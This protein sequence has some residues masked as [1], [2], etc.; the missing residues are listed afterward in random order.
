[1]LG[2]GEITI[3]AIAAL[4]IFF[5]TMVNAV[6]GLRAVAPETLELM[7]IGNASRLDVLWRVR[8]PNA[9]PY[10]LAGLQI[11][12][13]TCIL[14]AM[15]AEWVATGSGLGYLILQAGVQFQI[16]L[17]TAGVLLA[18]VLALAIFALTGSIARL[19]MRDTYE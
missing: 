19:L 6:L 7:A 9:V 12:A 15:V 5:P 1:M 2:N 16:G 13:A 18:A 11:G 10:V 14:G 17:M 4:I 3:M 8:L